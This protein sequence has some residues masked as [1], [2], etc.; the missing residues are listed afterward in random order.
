MKSMHLAYLLAALI[1]SSTASAAP[2]TRTLRSPDGQI[3]I[4]IDGAESLHYSVSLGGRPL[5]HNAELWLDVDHM[6]LGLQPTLNTSFS[7]A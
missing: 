2:W 4:R 7:T 3:E 1:P 5:L 6:K